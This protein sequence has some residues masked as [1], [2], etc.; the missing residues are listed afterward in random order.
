MYL[1]FLL[2][3]LEHLCLDFDFEPN[4][5]GWTYSNIIPEYNDVINRDAINVMEFVTL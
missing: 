4:I 5:S 2:S 1:D 3:D